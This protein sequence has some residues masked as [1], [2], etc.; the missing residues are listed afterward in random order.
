MSALIPAFENI[1]WTVGDYCNASCDH[2][3]T[4][5]VRKDGTESLTAADIDTV[6]EQL[7]RIGAR[8]VNIG[9]NEP[10]F[11]HGR[12]P[13]RSALPY[14]IRRLHDAD[15]RVGL[16][17]N[18][19]TFARLHDCHREALLLLNDIDFSLD[20]PF[21]A[22][23][24]R[25]RGLDLYRLV[26]SSIRRS[27]ELGI[28]CS[29]VMCGTH[30]T[31]SK[32]Y[33]AASIALS[34]LLG[35]ELRF[36]ILKPI[37]PALVSKMPSAEQYFDGFHYLLRNTDCVTLGEPSISALTGVGARG[38]SCGLSSFRIN[39]KTKDGKIP[40]S[41]CVYLH[42]L[43]VGDLLTEDIRHVVQSPTFRAFQARSQDSPLACR[44]A[45]CQYLEHCRGGCAARSFY[46]HGDMESKDI[47]CPHDYFD[48]VG[49]AHTFAGALTPGSV[50]GVRV[51]DKYLCTWI[52]RVNA[53]FSRGPYSS[54]S[55]F[56]S[57]SEAA[58]Q[59]LKEADAAVCGAKNPG[60]VMHS[61]A[62][63]GKRPATHVTIS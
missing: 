48:R 25:G 50:P 4:S 31:F 56:L 59:G 34:D 14:I 63:E 45:E 44:K 15:I 17:T 49:R 24:D 26:L 7:Q 60:E 53:R 51:H 46:M 12:D 55:M 23:H 19:T 18:G 36:N 29:M 9:G 22:E 20:S 16:T 28:D 52:G 32:E 43:R 11:T 10:I 41:P 21:E 3:Y 57:S 30:R 61:C 40:I 58:D 37:K 33:L 13:A 27:R 5:K 39:G 47:Y 2:C 35:C 1:G 42:G 8:T 38:C 62:I 54:L 6:V